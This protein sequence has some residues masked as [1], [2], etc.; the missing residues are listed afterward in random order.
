[1]LASFARLDLHQHGPCRAG[2][3]GGDSDLQ[4]LVL[5]RYS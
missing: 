3:V 1:M 4:Q 2:S 5:V